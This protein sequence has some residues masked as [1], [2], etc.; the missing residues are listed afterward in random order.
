MKADLLG[1]FYE[2][3]HCK[4]TGC[5]ASCPD[6]AT[7]LK[8]V[9]AEHILDEKSAAQAR[10][11]MQIV[12]QLEHQLQRE[13]EKLQAM[14]EYLGSLQRVTRTALMVVHVFG[15]NKMIIYFCLKTSEIRE[16]CSNGGIAASASSSSLEF[17]GQSGSSS[18]RGRLPV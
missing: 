15:E 1:H 10:V 8:H 6:L 17:L 2:G 5:E 12:S 3:G 11:Q 9:S 16:C 4:W 7:F 13:R 18:N 14:M